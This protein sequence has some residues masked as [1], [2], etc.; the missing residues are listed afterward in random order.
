MKI[1]V[2]LLNYN[3]SSDCKKC[4]SFL[5]R[6]QG[7]ELEIV[8]VDNCSRQNE[9]E[10]LRQLCSQEDCTLIENHEN[11]GYNAGNN[12]GLRYAVS[13]G[14]E[15]ALI[16]N[17]DM[18]F[19]ETNYIA[20]LISALSSQPEVAV[21]ASDIIS[22]TGK[23][24]NPQREATYW[25][26]L[27]WF[28]PL[29]A[30]RKTRK[31]FLEDYTKDGYCYKVGGCCLMIRLKVLQRINFFDENVFLYCEEAIL[32]KQ[33]QQIGE[34]IYYLSK[35]VAVHC[36]LKESKGNPYKRLTMAFNS[37]RYFLRKYSGYSGVKLKFLLFSKWV[38]QIIYKFFYVSGIKRK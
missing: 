26:E 2:I 15:Y 9:V 30:Y 23:H 24:L 25:E 16:A 19:P 11:R 34:K 28:I 33:I 7:V 22:P 27:L 6:Q 37:R 3:S 17:P 1:P 21:C 32:A 36:H 12:I 8:V 10:Q 29:L 5:K 35:A 4:I 38:Q 18:E 20:H 14:Y 13:K 31:W